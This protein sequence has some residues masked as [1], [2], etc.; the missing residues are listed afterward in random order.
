MDGPELASAAAPGAI[1]GAVQPVS[2]SNI[3]TPGIVSHRSH[4]LVIT[5]VPSETVQRPSSDEIQAIVAD[6][7]KRAVSYSNSLPNFICVEVTD[8]S[9]D[10]SGRGKWKHLD[11]IAELLRFHDN[12]ESRQ[13]LDVNGKPSTQSQDELRGKNGATS[14][15]EFGGVLKAVFQ[16]AAK[17]DFQWKETDAIGSETVQVLSYRVTRENSSW[18]LAGNDN[19][20]LYPSF[21]GLLYIDSATR[22]VR[23]ITLEADDLPRDFS[24]HS[25]SI[26][27]DYDYVAIGAH[28]YLMPVRGTVGLQQGKREAVLN[29]IE[30]RNYRRYASNVKIL[31]GGQPLH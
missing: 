16:P 4:T 13:T 7:R 2:D 26:V 6:A 14:W 31:Y 15:G 1:A 9:I 8:R 25:A 18:G 30:F 22:N 27:V 29:E 19:W 23:R 3:E 17:T 10:P 11:S 21:H 5:S 20:T 12:A 24:I 28:D